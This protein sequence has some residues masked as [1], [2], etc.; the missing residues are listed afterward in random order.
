MT[1]SQKLPKYAVVGVV[2]V[3]LGLAFSG[4]FDQDK[5]AVVVDVQVPELSAQALKGKQAFNATCAQC[6]GQNASGTDKGPPLIHQI[7][8]PGHHA[9]QAFL[10]AAKRGVRQ[11]H[12][13]YGDMPPQPQVTGAQIAAIVK[14][15]RELQ[16]A[17]GITYKPHRM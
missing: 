5:Q 8:N 13:P 11:H 1:I 17:N 14:Y 15:V 9:D 12:W 2:L 7:Y 10:L 6:H 3:G 4:L 16:I